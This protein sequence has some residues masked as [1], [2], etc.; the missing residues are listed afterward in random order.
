MLEMFLLWFCDKTC[1]LEEVLWLFGCWVPAECT[2]LW[3]SS[4]LISLIFDENFQNS[5]DDLIMWDHFIWKLFLPFLLKDH[6]RQFLKHVYAPDTR[7][8]LEQIWEIWKNLRGRQLWSACLVLCAAMVYNVCG[9]KHH[10][11]IT[12]DN[13]LQT[14]FQTTYSPNP[15]YFWHCK[16]KLLHI[17]C[18]NWT[19]ER[20]VSPFENET[21]LGPTDT[22][23]LADSL[24][25][26][27]ATVLE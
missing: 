2:V 15:L 8:Y 26:V 23:K 21:H 16:S 27:L 17:Y 24:I 25:F 12:R 11:L 18:L 20:K 22:Y 14:E 6:L 4:G 19:F 9:K 7:H 13:F 10:N 1:P 5:Q 3:P